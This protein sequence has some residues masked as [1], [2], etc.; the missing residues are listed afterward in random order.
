MTNSQIIWTLRIKHHY[1]QNGLCPDVDMFPCPNTRE[2]MNRRGYILRKFNQGEWRLLDILD[3][4]T[5]ADEQY[6]FHVK[7]ND[8]KLIY[9]TAAGMLLPEKAIKIRVNNVNSTT[10]IPE[11]TSERTN[12]RP[13]IIFE[14]DLTLQDINNDIP[15]TTEIH[16]PVAEYFWEYLFIHR[17]S[18]SK[19]NLSLQDI[20]NTVIF[21]KGGETDYQN[22]KAVLFRSLTK[23]PCSESYPGNLTLTETIRDRKRELMRQLPFPQPGMFLDAPPD[24]IRQVLYV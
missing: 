10:E 20:S 19:G 14:I 1:Y 16:I 8:N 24:V 17:Y 18:E 2:L 6:R 23:I 9:I 4:G 15:A 7:M 12:S 3:T 11:S 21:T 22:N 5:I 13:G